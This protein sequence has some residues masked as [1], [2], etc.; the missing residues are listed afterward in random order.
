M[1][2]LHV[3]RKVEARLVFL[4]N[5]FMKG[6]CLLL[7]VGFSI[8]IILCYLFFMKTENLYGM[9]LCFGGQGAS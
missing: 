9:L 2:Y 5:G 3:G 1:C 6:F 8:K 4:R 7:D